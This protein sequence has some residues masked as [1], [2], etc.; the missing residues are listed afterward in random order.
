MAQNPGIKSWTLTSVGSSEPYR[1][2]LHTTPTNIGYGVVCS[3]G[4]MYSIEHTFDDVWDMVNPNTS[5]VW[6]PNPVVVATSASLSN[7][8]YAF[9]PS[10]IRISVSTMTT[11]TS[12]VVRFN[13]IQAGWA[14]N[15]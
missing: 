15:R 12:P 2:N 13:L 7:G 5:A 14:G 9:S 10:A 11:S 1:V 8:N 3:G 6:F 4:A